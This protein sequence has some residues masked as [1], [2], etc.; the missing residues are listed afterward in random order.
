MYV[1]YYVCV[2]VCVCLS[3]LYC[4]HL[5]MKYNNSIHFGCAINNYYDKNLILNNIAYGRYW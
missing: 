5:S 1:L 4:L 2:C 3:M